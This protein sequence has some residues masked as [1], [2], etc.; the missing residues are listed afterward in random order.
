MRQA[1]HALLIDEVCAVGQGR[2][3][4]FDADGTLWRG[5][6]GEDFL[7]FAAQR[8]LFPNDVEYAT[9]EH[10]LEQSPPYAYGWCVEILKGMPEAQLQEHCDRF[11]NERFAGRVF[12]F[13]RPMLERLRKAGITPWICSASP[14]WAV[15]PGARA[16]GIDPAHVIG[17]TC[18]T[19]DGVL[20]GVVD[21]PVPV[22]PGK[23]TWLERRGVKPLLGVGNGDF[24]VD[25]LAA[26]ERA[27]VIAPPDSDNGLVKNAR[28]RGW[29]ILRA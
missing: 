13:V 23:V 24:D 8:K 3:V 6:V 28:E 16:L 18:S 4:V 26:S 29:P 25:M 7:R 15:L 5:D 22:G 12:A 1:D 17:V 9:Y 27:L 11:F 10:H 21:Q 2:I 14:R 20:T 19:S